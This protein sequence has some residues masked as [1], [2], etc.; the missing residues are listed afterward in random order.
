MTPNSEG[1]PK[2]LHGSEPVIQGTHSPYFLA[3]TP[4]LLP[5]F[6]LPLTLTLTLFSL[7][8]VKYAMT[9]WIRQRK[10]GNYFGDYLS[11]ADRA[12]VPLPLPLPLLV[13]LTYLLHPPSCPLF[14]KA[15]DE[16]RMSMRRR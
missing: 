1:D 3:F 16:L 15:R 12:K 8:G 14:T 7:S 5:A 13:L 4:A 10:S 11:A 9:K 6:A 2:S